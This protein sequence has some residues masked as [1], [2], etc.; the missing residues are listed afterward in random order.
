MVMLAASIGDVMDN[1]NG[2]WS[3]SWDTSGSFGP[4]SVTVTATDS[5]LESQFVSFDVNVARI[6]A[7]A[8]SVDALEGQVAMN[9]GAYFVP[10]TGTVTLS[11]SIGD[12]VDQGDGTWL[13]S[14]AVE[15]G[16]AAEMV[17]VTAEYSDG[18]TAEVVF[19]LNVANVAP[20]I[21]VDETVVSTLQ[22]NIAVNTGS[23]LD[24]G[25]DDVSLSASVGEVL[26]MGDGVWVWS[27]ETAGMTG[28]QFVSI[29]A[30]DSDGDMTM[31]DFEVVIGLIIA[32]APAVAIV[33]GA[34]VINDGQYVDPGGGTIQL[35]ASVGTVSDHGDG[36]WSWSFDATDGPDESQTV[37]ITAAYSGGENVSATFDLVVDNAAPDVSVEIATI[38]VNEGD[39]AMNT[40]VYS[41]L[42]EDTVSLTA[43]I[44]TIIDHGDGTW[45]WEMTVLDFLETTQIMITATDSDGATGMVMFDLVVQP[46]GD[47][48]E[49]G[50]H[51]CIDIDMLVAEI[52][53]STNSL[54]FDL[55]SNGMVD[56]ADRD[57]WLAEAG[58]INL[59]SQSTYLIGD[60]NL[61]G[62]VD[63]NDFLVWNANKFNS[64]AA[65]C[66]GDFSANGV[67]DGADFLL[68]N[69][70]K[71]MNAGPIFHD[72]QT[73]AAELSGLS[74]A[75]PEDTTDNLDIESVWR[76]PV[77]RPIDHASIDTSPE[78]SRSAASDA[79][80][81]SIHERPVGLR[82]F[83]L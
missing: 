28:S 45:G 65:W 83:D 48:N 15:D 35:S 43:S 34:T 6:T 42:G 47:F 19:D 53:A 36:T 50:V 77:L 59:S 54:A 44:G 7:I 61:D 5:E 14:S 9:S 21:V 73:T 12:V 27:M 17:T 78:Q 22:G 71:F 20:Q 29:S 40:G 67:I 56:I 63:G 25:F 39:V 16:P 33:E 32:N 23:Y 24:A 51:D 41:D 55:D 26:D 30:T 74:S 57:L 69:A 60:A 64:V 3:W 18:A 72:E 31:L 52:V 1:G 46:D 49:D 10:D 13:W 82:L 66:S 2:T 76:L 80:F 11:A 62:A 70:N 75:A 58:S 38:N 79:W 81:A 37:M 68:W 4:Q 8:A